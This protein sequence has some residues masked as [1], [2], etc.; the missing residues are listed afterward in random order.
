MYPGERVRLIRP[1]RVPGLG[2][3]LEYTIGTV[4]SAR[5]W[6]RLKVSVT[7]EKGRTITIRVTRRGVMKVFKEGILS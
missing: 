1:V 7:I 4:V 3:I 5:R 6:R 2:N